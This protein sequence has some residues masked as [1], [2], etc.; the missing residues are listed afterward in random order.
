MFI[1]AKQ[2]IDNSSKKISDCTIN[3]KS[4]RQITLVDN[5]GTDLI[6][7][8]SLSNNYGPIV[9][10]TFNNGDTN[11]YSIKSKDMNELEK[12]NNK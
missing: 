5:G 12:I 2:I 7:R 11:E 8:M 1:K 4:I 6:W 10:I 3:T 9:L